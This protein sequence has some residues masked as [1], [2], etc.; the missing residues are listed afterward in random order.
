MAFAPG[1]DSYDNYSHGPSLSRRSSMAYSGTPYGHQ[2]VYGDSV[3]PPH[4]YPQ[5]SYQ[6]YGPPTSTAVVPMSHRLTGTAY[7]DDP[8]YDE[9]MSGGHIAPMTPMI[10]PR[11]RRRS[12]VSFVSRPP[13]VDVY[14]RGS[15]VHIKFKRKG[16]FTAG[17]GLDEAQSRIRLS[18]NDS[19]TMHDLHADHRGRIMIRVRWAGYSSLTYEIPLEGY[20]GRVNLQT[21]ARRVSRACVHYLQANVIPIVWN[22][23]QLHHLEEVSYGVWQ[24]MLSS[25]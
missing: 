6:I 25:H 22:R 14:R 2:S 9:S 10:R 18:S 24:P 16:A 1:F 17:I 13:P 4:D 11:Q 3:M 19:Y 15:G 7:D 5:P 23:V 20:D 8:Y 21:L 12:S